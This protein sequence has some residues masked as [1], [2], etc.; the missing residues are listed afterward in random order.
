M[1]PSRL[2]FWETTHKKKETGEWVSKAAK[3]IYVSF[4]PGELNIVQLLAS[5]DME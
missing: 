3:E 1:P 4:L 2:K 5:S